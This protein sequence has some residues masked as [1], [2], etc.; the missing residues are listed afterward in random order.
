MEKNK[1][2]IYLANPLGFTEAGRHFLHEK[3][4]PTIEDLGYTVINPFE[5]ISKEEVEEAKASDFKEREENLKELDRGMGESNRKSIENC[6]IV[7][8]VLEGSDVDSG[9][10]AEVGYATG[11]GKK[12][13]GYRSD[14]R[15]S[16]ENIGTEINLQV[17]YFIEKSG[18]RIFDSLDELRSFLTRCST[19]GN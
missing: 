1:K 4:I 8:A 12:I 19:E 18:G 3:L 2:S 11:I 7:I 17:Q 10:A 15:L 16:S 5:E 13:I 6:D 14:F 9:T